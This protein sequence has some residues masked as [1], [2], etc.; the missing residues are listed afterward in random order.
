MVWCLL[1][2]LIQRKAEEKRYTMKQWHLKHRGQYVSSRW[3]NTMRNFS[4]VEAK[5]KQIFLD[6]NYE[7]LHKCY[8]VWGKPWSAL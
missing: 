2:S 5:E 7:I 3:N 4:S 8:I 6:L 1:F